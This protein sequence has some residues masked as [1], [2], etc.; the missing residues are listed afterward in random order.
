MKI[1]GKTGRRDLG[2]KIPVE[3]KVMAQWALELSR[4][5]EELSSMSDV[6]RA[7]DIEL[8]EITR[9]AARST[10]NLIE[11]LDGES[12]E[13]LPMRELI[14]FDKQLRSIRGTLKVEMAKKVELQQRIE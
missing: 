2:L 1:L 13:D 8:Q 9:N 7:D 5:E 6:A 10:D 3:G 4:I 11:Q 12:S 14:S